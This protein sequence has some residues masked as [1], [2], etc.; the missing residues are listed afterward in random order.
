MADDGFELGRITERLAGQDKALE[1]IERAQHDA[2]E[3]MKTS[4]QEL[5][6][7]RSDINLLQDQQKGRAMK[8]AALTALAAS[9]PGALILLWNLL[10]G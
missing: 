7:M 3:E 4:R 8:A 9:I 5:A 6:T 10:K 2:R 1:R